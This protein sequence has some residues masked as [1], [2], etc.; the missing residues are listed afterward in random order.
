MEIIPTGK[1]RDHSR[2]DIQCPI[3][4]GWYPDW[5]KHSDKCAAEIDEIM[6]VATEKQTRMLE[7]ALSDGNG[8]M[9]QMQETV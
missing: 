9:P 1:I 7:E 5:Y 4:K 6:R 2:M 3:C 8:H